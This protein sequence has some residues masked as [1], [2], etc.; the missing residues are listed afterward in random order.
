LEDVKGPLGLTLLYAPPEPLI[1]FIFVHGLGGGS[2]K[3]WS[4][5]SNLY[6]YWP[7]EW[8]PRDPDFKNVRIHTFGYNSTWRDKKDS[9]LDIH[10]FAHSLVGE[11]KDSPE[12]KADDVS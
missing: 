3:S 12:I 10:D 4:K 5:T 6:H 1:D 11:L 2:R 7:K 8:L 9:V